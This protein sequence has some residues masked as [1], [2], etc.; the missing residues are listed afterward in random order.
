MI[1]ILIIAILS[2]V[3][4]RLV[5]GQPIL[6]GGRKGVDGQN[7][8]DDYADYEEIDDNEDRR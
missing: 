8:G 7:R 4:Y 3:L 1:K 2:I 5:T 6:G